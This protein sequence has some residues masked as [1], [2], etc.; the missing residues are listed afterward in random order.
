MFKCTQ[1]LCAW[2]QLGGKVGW[3]TLYIIYTLDYH[4]Q[5]LQKDRAIKA[6]YG[7]EIKYGGTKVAC[8]KEQI[9]S[10][11]TNYYFIGNWYLKLEN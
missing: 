5:S 1:N 6:R 8:E 4:T 9:C 3:S 10:L 11:H 7:Y 2:F